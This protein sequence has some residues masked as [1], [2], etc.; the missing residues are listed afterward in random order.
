MSETFYDASN[1]SIS[2]G[3][4]RNTRYYFK[5]IFKRRPALN[6]D[7]SN[8]SEGTRMIANPDFELLGKI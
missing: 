4:K 7:I 3:F 8:S 6:A 1:L 2:N 5:K